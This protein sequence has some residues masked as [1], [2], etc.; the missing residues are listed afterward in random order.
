MSTR[1]K[2][3]VPPDAAEVRRATRH[4]LHVRLT[5]LVVALGVLA[6]LQ[7]FWLEPRQLLVRD[8]VRLGLPLAEWGTPSEPGAGRPPR[9]IH[10]SD[11]HIREE[12]PVL[13]RLLD[14]VRAER[15]DLVLISGDL[16]TDSHRPAVTERRL[17]TTAAYLTELRRVA[18]VLAVQGHSEYQ[19]EVVATLGRAGVRWLSNEGILADPS[20][21]VILG[22]NEQVGLDAQPGPDGRLH[23]PHAVTFELR[24]LGDEPRRDPALAV[25]REGLEDNR[26]LH[27]DPFG[28]GRRIPLGDTRG[29]L[30]WSGYE[31][32]CELWIDD[33]DDGA[34]VA[35][36]SRYVVGEDRMV[37]LR[38]VEAGA[39]DGGTFRLVPHGTAFTAGE[40]DTGVS[41]QPRRWYRVRLRTDVETRGG[42]DLVKVRA[43]VWPAE[44]AEPTG[45]QAQVEDRSTTRVTAGTVGLWGWED[46]GAAYRHLRLVD[47]DGRVLL[48]EAF[49]GNGG[50]L[51]PGWREGARGSRIALALA[52]SP[53]VPPGT[54]R[55]VLSHTPGV[56]LEAAHRGLDVVLAGHTHGG[57]VRLPILGAL[58][59][60]SL[61]GAHYD[62]GV[63]RFGSP[64]LRGWTTLHISS[65]I[66]TSIVP[67]RTFNPPRYAVIHPGPVGPSGLD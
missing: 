26:Y 22:L 37:R 48:E 45:W 32:S 27:W 59:T 16:I 66:G 61:L 30:S 60:R 13:R 29:P 53:A 3:S 57:Q 64:A 1:R 39:E 14:A 10:L 63:F 11:L 52:R 40:P 42:E 7:A 4:R 9:W 54:P 23:L 44:A 19:G 35:V 51:P 62:R 25:V 65:G 47:D 41:P 50:A 43:K 5:V 58:T 67:L 46:G 55:V 17:A 33:R 21:P 8:E 6:G 31:V 34:G 18:P 38:R 12:T 56:L 28:G 15:P 24:E 49:T 20:G 2:A 36:H